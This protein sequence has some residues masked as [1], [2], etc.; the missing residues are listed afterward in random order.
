MGHL[1]IVGGGPMVPAISDRALTLAG[2]K[3][4]RVLIV[5]QASELRDSGERSEEMW[6][7]AAAHLWPNW[8]MRVA[9]L[10]LKNKP[11]DA[12]AKADLI[13]MPGGDQGRLMG[14][15]KS[16]GIVAAIQDRFRHGATVGG[17]SAGAAVMSMAMLTAESRVDRLIADTNKMADGLGLW[18]DVI[19]DQH[20][21]TR[22]RFT[23]LLTAVLNHSE[24]VGIGIDES[25]A[26]VV[27]GRS[28]EVIGQSD[29]VIID[30]RNTAKLRSRNGE[31]EAATNVALHILRAGMRFHLDRGLLTPI[32]K[33]LLTKGLLA[34]P[35][36]PKASS[37][38]RA[39]VV[40]PD[41]GSNHSRADAAAQTPVLLRSIQPR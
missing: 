15:L 33:G 13:W 23:R 36:M 5:P 12:I 16:Q 11:L 30:A 8:R 19:V 22:C 38:G 31:P 34:Q 39:K 24:K 3:T 9:I 17:T 7:Q 26:V 14:V 37:G 20:F 35:S 40:V 29:V 1:I 41:V 18:P 2:G 4:A 32:D 27:S 25:T 10:D 21:L 28:F 6:R